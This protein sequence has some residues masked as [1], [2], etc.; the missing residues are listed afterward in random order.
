MNGYAFVLDDRF[1]MYLVCVIHLNFSEKVTGFCNLVLVVKTSLP[2]YTWP[3]E[4]VL[5]VVALPVVCPVVLLHRASI[6]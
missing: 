4:L 2:R 5:L 1:D 6:R 3:V